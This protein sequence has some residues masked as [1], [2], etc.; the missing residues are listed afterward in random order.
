M[1]TDFQDIFSTSVTD[2]GTT[3]KVSQCIEL[4]NETPFQ[5]RHRRMSPP[6]FKEILA[7]GI[8]R[9]P[10]SPFSSNFVLV[11]KS[12]RSLL[13]CIDYRQM[14][15]RIIRDNYAY[16]GMRKFGIQLPETT[17]STKV[18]GN[19]GFSCRKHLFQRIGYEVGVWSNRN[20][21]R[22]LGNN[23]FHSRVLGI[24]RVQ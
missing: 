23:C 3:A 14:N 6:A 1:V 10:H 18:W 13:F 15:S 9:P 20:S 16:Q 4:A 5:Q 7:A 17:M 19:L 22:K 8:I 11:R 21:R 2:T 12:D 24:L